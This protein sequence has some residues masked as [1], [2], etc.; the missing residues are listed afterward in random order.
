MFG[1]QYKGTGLGVVKPYLLMAWLLARS[2]SGKLTWLQGWENFVTGQ[3][4]WETS[5]FRLVW[6]FSL[7]VFFFHN[8]GHFL[9]FVHPQWRR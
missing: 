7:R 1:W 9:L 2:C 8:L 3:V 5:F 4:H 6:K